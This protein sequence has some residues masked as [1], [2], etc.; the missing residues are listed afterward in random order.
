[1]R[2]VKEKNL[3]PKQYAA[4]AALLKDPSIPKAAKA[5]GVTVTTV[6]RWMGQN[7]FASELRR[8]EGELLTGIGRRLLALGDQAQMAVSDGLEPRQAINARLRAAE[9]VFGHGAKL[10][11]LTDIIRRLEEIERRKEIGK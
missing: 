4:L 10:A 5:A 3:S 11:E 6:Y 2:N 8:L 9:I 7:S 1:M